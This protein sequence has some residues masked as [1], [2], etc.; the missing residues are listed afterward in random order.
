MISQ[1][2]PYFKLEKLRVYINNWI[3]KYPKWCNSYNFEQFF[4]RKYPESIPGT[5]EFY[6]VIATHCYYCNRSFERDT[7]NF[8]ATIDHFEPKS[9]GQTTKYVIACIDCNT[10]K[11]NMSPEIL[12]SRFGYAHL[13]GLPLWG[14][15]GKKLKFIYTQIQK[16]NNDRLYNMGPS[17]YY[18][19]R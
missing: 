13:R 8:C 12:L 15:Q 19:K 10:R 18:I 9:L 14:Y 16:I 1:V 6:K 5:P 11:G 4:Y 3:D 2:D 7:K 17:V